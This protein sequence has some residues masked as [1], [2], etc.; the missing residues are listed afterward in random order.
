MNARYHIGRTALFRTVA[1]RNPALVQLL[2]DKGA[3]MLV[4]DGMTVLLLDSGEDVKRVL[5][6]HLATLLRVLVGR[7]ITQDGS[8]SYDES[9]IDDFGRATLTCRVFSPFPKSLA[10]HGQTAPAGARWTSYHTSLPTSVYIPVW[11][12]QTAQRHNPLA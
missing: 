4:E 11:W 2:L 9:R 5:L 1:S 6:D 10:P 12:G 8:A 3:D 7:G